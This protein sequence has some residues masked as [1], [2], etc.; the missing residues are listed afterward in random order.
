MVNFLRAL[1]LGVLPSV[2]RLIAATIE[3]YL[4]GVDDVSKGGEVE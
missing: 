1:A 4:D 2:L 3:G